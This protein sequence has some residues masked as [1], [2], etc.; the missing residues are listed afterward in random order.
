[1]LS[2][3]VCVSVSQPGLGMFRLSKGGD[4]ANVCELSA[5][6]EGPQSCLILGTG[7]H[8]WEVL[9]YIRHWEPGLQRLLSDDLK[10]KWIEVQ[11][12]VQSQVMENRQVFLVHSTQGPRGFAWG[13]AS[14]LEY[15]Q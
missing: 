14:G 2:K 13:Q 1:M 9:P 10:G 6:S 8:C 3:I 5:S 12:Q 15:W 11:P 4:V 7:P